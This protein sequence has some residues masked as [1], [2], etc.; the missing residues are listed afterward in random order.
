[1]MDQ[2]AADDIAEIAELERLAEL[3]AQE[4]V[5]AMVARMEAMDGPAELLPARKGEPYRTAASTIDAFWYV[6]GLRDQ[7][8]FKAWLADRPQDAPFLLKLMEGT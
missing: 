6:V 8:R 4:E 7:E 5:A 1:M 2:S 3:R